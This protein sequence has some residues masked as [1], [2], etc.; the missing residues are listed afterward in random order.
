MVTTQLVFTVKKQILWKS[1][2][3][4]NC[5]LTII[6]LNIFFNETRTGLNNMRVSK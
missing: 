1:M 6:F 3:I 4:I 5:V 2:E